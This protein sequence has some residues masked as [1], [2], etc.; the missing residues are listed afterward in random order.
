MLIQR[1][2]SQPEKLIGLGQICLVVG[3]LCL[4][5]GC[6]ATL[7][8]SLPL[9]DFTAGFLIGFGATLCGL[10]IVLNA[11]GLLLSRGAGS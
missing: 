4:G 11:R 1:Y 10:S 8:E 2:A 5:V 6:T 9:G 7:T 3:L